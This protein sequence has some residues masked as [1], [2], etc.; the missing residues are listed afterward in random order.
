MYLEFRATEWYLVNS[1]SCRVTHGLQEQVH[2]GSLGTRQKGLLGPDHTAYLAGLHRRLSALAAHRRR[3][4]RSCRGTVRGRTV[5][6]QCLAAEPSWGCLLPP[7]AQVGSLTSLYMGS[8]RRDGWYCSHS[9]VNTA[10]LPLQQESGITPSESCGLIDT[11]PS[12]R[13]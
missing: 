6:E 2:S 10:S 11:H 3:A 8:L 13:Q 5:G 12:P 9:T 1:L 4:V 7:P